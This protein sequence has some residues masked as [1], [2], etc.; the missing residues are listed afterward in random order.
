LAVLTGRRLGIL[1]VAA[2]ATLGLTAAVAL[3]SVGRRLPVSQARRF[4]SAPVEV[5]DEPPPA[6]PA[7][8]GPAAV[9]ERFAA[10]EAAFADGRWADAATAFGWVVAQDPGGPHA[11]PAQWN[12]TRSRLRSGDGTGALAALEDLIRHHA[13]YLGREAPALRA[14]L[15]R[16]EAGD[17]A[18]ARADLERMIAEQPGSELVPLAWALIARIHWTHGE[19]METLRAF[20]RMFAAVKDP[21]PAYSRLAYDLERYARGDADV[22]ET[23]GRL[24]REGEAGFRDIYQYLAARSLLEQDRFDAAH[25]ALETLRARHPGGDFTHIVDLEH[26]WNLL[27]HQRAAEALVI[28]ER[29]EKTEAP[30]GTQGFDAFFDLR[31]EVP[32]GIARCHLALGHYA[33]AAAVLER[34]TAERPES[35][36][37]VED[38]VGLAL[39]YERLGRLDRAAD[40]L[41]RVIAERADEPKLWALRQ[42]L[43]RIEA[44]LAAAP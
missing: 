12:L 20:A 16:M 44:R 27:R 25:D 34:A 19:P 32:L 30:A 13:G 37:A 3:W 35:M 29:L 8:A 17:L 39:A 24:A 36:Y 10:A 26:A 28:F 15:E 1:V 18:G 7:A 2:T 14:G 43:A 6:P 22:A 40:V 21:V 42:Q 41:R 33:E 31:A 11:G 23:F 4:L 9:A 5:G 38:Q